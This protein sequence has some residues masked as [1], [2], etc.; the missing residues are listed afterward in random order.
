MLGADL[1]GQLRVDRILRRLT[2]VD[3]V[4]SV[5]PSLMTNYPDG[6][7]SSFFTITGWNFPPDSQATLSLNG[8]VITRLLRTNATGSF[9][10]FLNTAG[11]GTGRYDVTV[12]VNPSATTSFT[13]ADGAPLRP[14]EGGGRTVTMFYSDHMTYL[15]LVLR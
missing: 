10:F 9:I 5:L 15:P 13:L 1:Y 6:Q 8:Q 7:P 11:A 2:P 14:Q 4:E 12:S 3:V